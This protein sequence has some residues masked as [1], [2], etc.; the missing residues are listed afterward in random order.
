[1]AYKYIGID[2]KLCGGKAVGRQLCATHY[3]QAQRAGTLLQ[4]K[5][6]NM[7]DHFHRRYAVQK[8]GCWE[9]IAGF[10]NRG[11][12]VIHLPGPEHTQIRAHQYS[13]TLHKGRIPKGKFVLHSCDNSKCVNPNH[14]RL[15]NHLENM[16][17]AVIRQ[18]TAKG[19]TNGNTVTS[20]AAV[21]AI[22]HAYPT[23]SLATLAKR[24]GISRATVY[25][26]VNRVTWKH[27]P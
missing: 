3:K 24:H 13:Y 15:G 26:I 5:A 8:S 20:E 22:R 1:M 18:R 2:C 4:Q 7:A 14:L 6:P 12:G 16:A 27:I 9:W 23:E 19:E 10:N 11:Y 17:D 21:K 25:Q